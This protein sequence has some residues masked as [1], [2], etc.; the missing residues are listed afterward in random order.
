M[1]LVPF[2]EIDSSFFSAWKEPGE[3]LAGPKAAIGEAEH[4]ES[5]MLGN[6]SWEKSGKVSIGTELLSG[7]SG[8]MPIRC[9]GASK[10][11]SR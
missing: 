3:S 6:L 2:V 7:E 10:V 11:S 5:F 1:I 9:C 4:Q 8:R